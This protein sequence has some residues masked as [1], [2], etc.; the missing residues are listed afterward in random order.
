MHQFKGWLDGRTKL[1]SY[2][3]Y[4]VRWMRREGDGPTLDTSTFE[5]L[6]EADVRLPN[7]A[8]QADNLVRWLGSHLE[9]PGQTI[10]LTP[11]E[12]MSVLGSLDATAFA[13]VLRHTKRVGL[14]EGQF[15]GPNDEY[16]EGTLTFEGWRYASELRR[17]LATGRKAF[18]AMPFGNDRLDRVFNECMKP[19]AEAAGFD[20]VR[21]DEQPRAGSIDDRLRVEIRGSRFLVAELT[22][23]NHG[24]YWEAGFAEGLGKPV[25]YTCEEQY[26]HEPGTH[27]DTNHHET[28][29]WDFA[30]LDEAAERLAATIRETFPDE[31]VLPE[32]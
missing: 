2:L 1:Q 15:R 25:I 12:Q 10:M 8:E 9:S 29:I 21:L 19:G 18:M 14:I 28:V 26:F 30:G 24:A 17:G 31:A 27:F 6:N 5:N 23:G 7:A 20:L 16:F 13:F 11:A 22:H 32:G 3:S 4:R